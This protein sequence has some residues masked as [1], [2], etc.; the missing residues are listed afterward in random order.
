MYFQPMSANQQIPFLHH[1]VSHRHTIIES[2]CPN[3]GDFVGASSDEKNLVIAE[4]AHVC[5]YPDRRQ[6]AEIKPP[7]NEPGTAH[8]S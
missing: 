7:H 2:V 8:G 3:C 6:A 4:A 5:D 1:R